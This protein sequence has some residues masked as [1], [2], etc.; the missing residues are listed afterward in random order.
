MWAQGQRPHELGVLIRQRVPV[1]V[2][3]GERFLF[4][5]ATVSGSVMRL[6]PNLGRNF[7]NRNV[8]RG[9][10]CLCSRPQVVY[11]Y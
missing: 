1:D 7:Q 5:A 4:R 9:K 6:F 8:A 2:L 3:L 11:H 10:N